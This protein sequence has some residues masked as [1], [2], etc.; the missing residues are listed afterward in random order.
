MKRL[1]Y[2]FIFFIASFF[3]IS[4]SKDNTAN[5][6]A[7]QPEI[8]VEGSIEQ[9][10]FP[11]VYLTR[12]IPY[13]TNVDSADFINLIIRQAKVVVSDGENTEVL[14]LMFDQQHFPPYYYRGIV[15]TGQVGKTYQLQIFYGSDT[16]SAITTIPVPVAIDSAWL[17]SLNGNPDQSVVFATIHD[18]PLVVNYYRTFTFS[19]LT[20]PGFYPTLESVFNDKLFNGKEYTFELNKG[21]VTY[22]NLQNF[23]D[24]F[25]MTDSVYVK[26]QTMNQTQY[27]F[28][29]DIQSE[30]LNTGNP[31]AS[32]FHSVNSNIKGNGVGIWGGYGATIKYVH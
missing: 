25:K 11:L 32:S 2:V 18:D 24:Y 31:F 10:G 23:N 22:L 20:Q 5:S 3:L 13:Y 21:P 4:C 8:V 29:S 16:L 17:Q 9:G 19:P 12:N 30:I 1:F 14:T 7:F 15:L 6:G 27:Q 28:W 26:I